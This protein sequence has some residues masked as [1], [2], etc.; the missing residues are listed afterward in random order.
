MSATGGASSPGLGDELARELDRLGEAEGAAGGRASRVGGVADDRAVGER[1]GVRDAELDDVGARL[2]ERVQRRER[3]RARR[4]A[5]HH[6][7][8]ERRAPVRE[9]APRGRARGARQSTP[10]PASRTMSMSLS[11]R[12]ESVTTT[13]ASGPS[14]SASRGSSASACDDS[15]AG[16][17]P[18]RAR[19]QLER[20]ER[21]GVGDR[22]VAHEPLV[23]EVRVLGPDAR[24]VEPRRDRVR[25]ERVARV[26]LEQVAVEAVHDAGRAE[27]H[28]CAGLVGV[29]PE[30]GRLGADEQR[31]C[32]AR[33]PPSTNG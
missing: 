9:R 2:G 13:T 11:P 8:D 14:S 27:R 33:R 3:L 18:S 20:R 7:G 25:L 30:P 10:S 4:V 15:M 5:G 6:V 12:P 29:E 26:V 28:R 24:V 1:V 19:E 17:M 22:L 32:R 23:L 16:M 31:A 21:L